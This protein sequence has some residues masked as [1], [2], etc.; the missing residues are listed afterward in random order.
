MGG[1][2][3][4]P[5]VDLKPGQMKRDLVKPAYAMTFSTF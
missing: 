4:D 1:V 2:A 5:P 3:V